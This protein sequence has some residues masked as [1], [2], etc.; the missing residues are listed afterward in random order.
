MTTIKI[1]SKRGASA[2][3]EYDD[4]GQLK[5]ATIP[6]ADIV[7]NEVSSYKL[8]MGIPHGLDWAKLITLQA[9]PELLE[10]NLRRAGIWTADDALNNAPKVLGA[11]QATYQ[12]DLGKL[13]QAA[14][15][16]KTKERK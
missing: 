14:K 10:Q 12:L 2:L 7:D 8:K 11:I 15:A 9:T 1:I 4:K 3:V 6:Q 13:L 16:A 5:R